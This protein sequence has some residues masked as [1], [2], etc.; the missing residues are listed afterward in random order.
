[1]GSKVL[2]ISGNRCTNPDPVFPLGLAHLNSAL[3]RAGHHTL[4]ADSLA[5]G[6][7]MESVLIRYQPDIVGISVRNID[8]ALIRKTETFFDDL[9]CLGAMIRQK[10]TCPVV[11]VAAAGSAFFPGNY[12]NCPAQIMASVVRARRVLFPC[13]PP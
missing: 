6:E 4:W 2:L 11:V 10:T 13:S 8:D 5:S 7:S 9:S 1:M 3:R 12:W